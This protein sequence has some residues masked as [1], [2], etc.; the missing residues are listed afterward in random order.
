M[1]IWGIKQTIPDNYPGVVVELHKEVRSYIE[2]FLCSQHPL[3]KGPVC[4][5][6]SDALKFNQIFFSYCSNED[7]FKEGLKD[8]LNFLNLPSESSHK[9]KTIVVLFPRDFSIA[10]LLT[11]Q[12]K[13]MGSCIR[14]GLMLGAF[15]HTNSTPSMYGNNFFPSR[16]PTPTLVI[17]KIVSTDKLFIDP[18]C[19]ESVED[20]LAFIRMFMRL[21]GKVISQDKKYELQIFHRKYLKLLYLKYLLRIILIALVVTGIVIILY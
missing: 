17:R 20:K 10:K 19:H 5:F 12:R 1:K 15:Y 2:N 11:Q 18:T 13:S 3:R 4:P 16:T 9:L 8:Y 14:A 7:D 21:H 6:V